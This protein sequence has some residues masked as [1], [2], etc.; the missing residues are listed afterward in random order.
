MEKKKERNKKSYNNNKTPQELSN[1]AGNS[2]W[3]GLGQVLGCQGSKR[4]RKM[5]FGFMFLIGMVILF[6]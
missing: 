6:N 5:S 1:L 3:V 2:I 4:K